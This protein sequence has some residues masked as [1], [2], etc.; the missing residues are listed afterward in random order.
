M[1]KAIRQ[2]GIG[3]TP[4]GFQQRTERCPCLGFTLW[5]PAEKDAGRVQAGALVA[6]FLVCVIGISLFVLAVMGS[7]AGLCKV[8]SS[9][10]YCHTAVAK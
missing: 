3:S 5:Q 10:S 7:R 2:V 8:D 9:H 4:P 1:C 6:T